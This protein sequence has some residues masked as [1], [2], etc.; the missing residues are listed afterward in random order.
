MI[1]VL[2]V[3]YYLSKKKIETIIYRQQVGTS[4]F[5]LIRIHY[6]FLRRSI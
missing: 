2:F 4:D 5:E 3:D 6:L 1:V